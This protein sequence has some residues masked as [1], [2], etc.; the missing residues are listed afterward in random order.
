M[1]D[2]ARQLDPL[3]FLCLLFLQL[4]RGYLH[5]HAKHVPLGCEWHHVQGACGKVFQG[6]VR[7]AMVFSAIR[8]VQAALSSAF[9]YSCS[10]GG[11][12]RVLPHG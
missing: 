2:G 11:G 9:N 6:P 3:E 1:G 12:G 7:F 4:D 10:G 8:V 5:M